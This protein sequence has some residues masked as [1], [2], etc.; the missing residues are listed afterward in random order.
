MSGVGSRAGA[1]TVAVVVPGYTR[2]EFTAEEE[3]SF[4]HIEHYLGSYDKYLLVPESLSI[5][6]PGFVLKR[7][8]DRFFG[9]ATAA[10]R[11][12]LSSCF[13][14]AFARYQYILLCHLDALVL[15]D[16]LLEWCETGFDYIASPWLKCDDSPWVS[17]ARVGNGGF[18]LRRIESFL[19]VLE[20]DQFWVDPDDYWTDFCRQHPTHRQFLG[21]PRRFLMRSRRFNNV[22]REIARWHLKTDGMGNEDYFWSDEAPRCD[23]TFRVAPFEVGLRFS[24]EVAPRKC[25]ELNHGRLPFGCH[26]WQKYD[27]A[28]WEPYLLKS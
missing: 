4:R 3:L 7:F 14:E 25:F 6:R 5:D 15:S 22:K 21:L 23:P 18:S 19:R 10:T 17:R 2:A 8:D 28:F 27:R 12:T 20:L 16:N 1:A 13:Y 11:F 26:A 9:S 24:F